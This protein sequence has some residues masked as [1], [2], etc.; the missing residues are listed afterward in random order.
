VLEVSGLRVRYGKAEAIRDISFRVSEGEI[1]G[2]V[3]P[4]GAGKST[5]LR[6][7]SGLIPD[8]EGSIRFCGEELA[9][10]R[11]HVITRLGLIHAPEGRRLFPRMT[12]ED[13]LRAGAYAS[14]RPFK[15]ALEDVFDLFPRLAERRSQFAGTLSGGEQQMVNIGRALMASPRL[16]ML[17][18]PSWGLAPLIIK[19]IGR[20]ILE[21][22]Q[23]RMLTIL[24]VEQNARLALTCS[25]RAY[26]VENGRIA[27]S[28]T[29]EQ[30]KANKHV[31]EV[32][33]G[34]AV[35]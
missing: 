35:L 15:A 33:V 32:Y 17:D 7:I 14:D 27:L 9:G 29:S 8:F 30:L 18:E 11:P 25:T 28:G 1:V 31:A 19:E 21:I 22:S 20:V 16:L 10:K 2:V 23:R 26:V 12:V 34:G 3:G 24:L 4:N 6:A 5:M 13:N